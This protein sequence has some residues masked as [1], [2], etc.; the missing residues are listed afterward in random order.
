MQEITYRK[1]EP[2]DIN[3]FI[4]LRKLQLIDEGSKETVDITDS[5]SDYFKRHLAD[6]TF[7]S[8]VAE[9]DGEIIATSGISFFEKPPYFNNPSGLI[10]LLSCMYT[11]PAYRRKGIAK[12]L[13]DLII[14]E[15]KEYGCTV[16][17]LTASDEGTLL[18]ENYGFLRNKDFFFLKVD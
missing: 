6:G 14:N 13:I 5:L 1:L 15:A 3:R 18:Y 4:E 8:W 7:I 2:K 12:K 17:Q 10:G 16:I 11:V 9:A